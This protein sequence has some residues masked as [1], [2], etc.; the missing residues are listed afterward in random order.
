ME[1]VTTSMS[2]CPLVPAPIPAPT[3]KEAI[4]AAALLVCSSLQIKGPVLDAPLTMVGV[5]N[6]A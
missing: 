3:L 4:S 6:S 2:A 5:V 1:H